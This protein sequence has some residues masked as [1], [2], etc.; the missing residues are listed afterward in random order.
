MAWLSP[1]V[2]SSWYYPVLGLIVLC[3][4]VTAH[5]G[6]AEQ[7]PPTAH[8]EVQYQNNALT[9]NL[10]HASLHDVLQRIAQHTG[11]RFHG[12]VKEERVSVMFR[13]LPLEQALKRLLRGQSF[14]AI[15]AR[16]EATQG[17]TGPETR[18]TE[19]WLLSEGGQTVH[20]AR[21]ESAEPAPSDPAVTSQTP[22]D[23]FR[24]ALERARVQQ[25]E[26]QVA[27]QEAASNAFREALMRAQREQTEGG[28]S[29]ESLSPAAEAFR[30]AL[31]RAQNPALGG[32]QSAPNPFQPQR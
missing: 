24:Q 27:D 16:T 3:L 2:R 19:V 12:T 7:P 9:V 11:V 5:G 8:L 21:Q 28:S 23:A 17:G 10:R 18:L 4:V 14:A 13:N 6:S 29:P 30:N 15:F 1:G 26:E 25:G 31:M 32:E 20:S 22:A